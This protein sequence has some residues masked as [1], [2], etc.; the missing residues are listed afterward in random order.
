[1]IMFET[2]RLLVRHW[3]PDRLPASRQILDPTLVQ[4]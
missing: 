3:Q 1:M 2:E 4:G